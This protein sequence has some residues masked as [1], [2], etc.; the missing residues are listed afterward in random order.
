MAQRF[1]LMKAK[2]IRWQTRSSCGRYSACTRGSRRAAQRSRGRAQHTRRVRLGRSRRQT[3][4]VGSRRRPRACRG[5]RNTA[6]RARS[7]TQQHPR[8]GASAI[9]AAASAASWSKSRQREWPKFTV[10]RVEVEQILLLVRDAVR[11]RGLEAQAAC[12]RRMNAAPERMSFMAGLIQK[13]T[14][15]RSDAQE[16][17]AIGGE[18]RAGVGRATQMSALLSPIAS[19]GADALD[20]VR[21]REASRAARHRTRQVSHAAA[22]AQGGCSGDAQTRASRRVDRAARCERSGM[23]GAARQD[24]GRHAP[25]AR[26]RR[27]C[28]CS[29]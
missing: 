10:G 24:E 15:S 17:A 2:T 18:R 27:A 26:R 23:N 25:A 20:V 16:H 19:S 4:A 14:I 6:S 12:T 5:R 11:A 29:D 13:L 3:T 28:R 21:H 1:S 22:R 8:F 9:Q 7:S